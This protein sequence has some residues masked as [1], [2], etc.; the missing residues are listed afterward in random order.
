MSRPEEGAG[1]A[2][3]EKL[4]SR[5]L[6]VGPDGPE[7]PAGP[8]EPGEER[9]SR[10]PEETAG[11][12]GEAG[13]T[14]AA[15]KLGKYGDAGEGKGTG[16]AGEKEPPPAVPTPEKE[17]PPGFDLPAFYAGE[18]PGG[19]ERGRAVHL[20]MQTLD[21]ALP[22]DEA[23]VRR[24]LAYLVARE[25]LRPEE[26]R[27]VLPRVIARFWRGELGRRVLAAAKDNR[28]WREVSFT[29]GVPVPELYPETA[30]R[31]PPEETV[32]L[33]GTIDCLL[34]EEDGLVIIDYKTDRLTENELPA[35]AERYRPQL[36]LYA[37]AAQQILGRPVREKYLYFFSLGRAVAM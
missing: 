25:I 4:P 22:P 24:H 35:A 10:G 34:A 20:V 29:L 15:G 7:K 23:A 13:K 6:T 33:Q 36:A 9:S 37:R 11:T 31:V 2:G 16:E 14:G 12:A 28:L 19:A 8:E 21:L 17:L 3:G 1:P 18:R 5:K 27:L 30:G 26:R 32:L